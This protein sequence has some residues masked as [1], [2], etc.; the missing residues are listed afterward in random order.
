M[1]MLNHPR[2]ALCVLDVA[3]ELNALLCL[4]CTILESRSDREWTGTETARGNEILYKRCQKTPIHRSPY[5]T[6]RS[7]L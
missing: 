5:G 3:I 4:A 7:P 1:Q 2:V 6:R